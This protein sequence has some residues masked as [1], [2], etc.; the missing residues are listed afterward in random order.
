MD[1]WCVEVLRIAQSREDVE[2]GSKAGVPASVGTNSER[3]VRFLL[4]L[5]LAGLM[6]SAALVNGWFGKA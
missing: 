2:A 5:C 1:V 3:K 6:Q 4:S